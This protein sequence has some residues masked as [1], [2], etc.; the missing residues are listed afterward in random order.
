MTLAIGARLGPYEVMAPI[1]AGGM[2]EV[3]RARDTKL[4]RDVT[5]EIFPS[6]VSLDAERLARFKCEAHFLG[7]L[8]RLLIAS[9]YGHE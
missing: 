3:D 4:K 6:E 1:G 5:I 7:S 8:N 9:S 2:G